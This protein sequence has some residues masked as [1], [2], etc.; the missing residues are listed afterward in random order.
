MFLYTHSYTNHAAV[1]T[2][3]YNGRYSC[4]SSRRERIPSRINGIRKDLQKDVDCSGKAL[5]TESDWTCSYWVMPHE[6]DTLIVRYVYKII[7]KF[8]WQRNYT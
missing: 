3:V 4:T 7:I 2:C 1:C 6:N 5:S 8:Y